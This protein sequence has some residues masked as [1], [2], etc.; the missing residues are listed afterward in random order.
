[1]FKYLCS[2]EDFVTSEKDCFMPIEE[3]CEDGCDWEDAGKV[4]NSLNGTL[5]TVDDDETMFKVS[6][7]KYLVNV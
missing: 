3:P 1:M 6:T 7:V 2:D 5:A 4:C